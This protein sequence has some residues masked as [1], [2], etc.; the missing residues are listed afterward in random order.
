[1]HL[2]GLDLN[3]LVVLDALFKEKNVTRAGKRIHLSQ[4]ATSA[5]LRRLREFFG[6][7]LLIPVGR[8]MIITPKGME[9]EEKVRD[10]ILQADA[11]TRNKTAFDP[12]TASRR[13]QLMMSDYPATV[14]LPEALARIRRIAPGLTFDILPISEAP[15]AK[16]ER[17]DIDLLIMPR[18]FVSPDHPFDELFEDGHVCVVWSGNRRVG[19]TMSLGRYMSM[20]HV[21]V[22]FAGQPV[23]VLDEWLGVQFGQERRVEVTAAAFNLLPS[24]VVGTERVATVHSWLARAFAKSLPVRIIPAPVEIPRITEVMQ[25]HK[26]RDLDSGIAWLRSALKDAVPPSARPGSRR[27]IR[28]PSTP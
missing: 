23:P 9:L 17:G 15:A 16:L 18:Q 1:M 24:L 8:K 26:S 21:S 14:F 7:E 3:L 19:K 4:S 28:K 12:A 20:G 11:V 22:Q 5:A 13:F 6:D 27:S 2:A 25:W 10:L